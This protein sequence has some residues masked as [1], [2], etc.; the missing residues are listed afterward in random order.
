[1]PFEEILKCLSN[2]QVDTVLKGLSV[3]QSM[4][5]NFKGLKKRKKKDLDESDQID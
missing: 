5:K 3:F 1:M 4:S 2:L